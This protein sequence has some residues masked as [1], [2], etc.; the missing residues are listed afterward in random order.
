MFLFGDDFFFFICQVL[1]KEMQH[2]QKD[3][4]DGGGKGNNPPNL[5]YFKEVFFEIVILKGG[6]RLN[7]DHS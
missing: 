3:F 4:G 2:L 6:P 7:S 1:K 5:I